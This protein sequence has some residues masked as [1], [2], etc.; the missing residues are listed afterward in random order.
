NDETGLGGGVGKAQ[1][2]QASLRE[3]CEERVVTL[4]VN[5]SAKQDENGKYDEADPAGFAACGERKV[6]RAG[7]DRERK[8][9]ERAARL[10]ENEEYEHDSHEHAV[11]PGFELG[12][13]LL[14]NTA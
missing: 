12:D 2:E 3:A 5:A 10:P 1:L 7:K 13:G 9:D 8:T 14:A 11:A 6:C 4:G